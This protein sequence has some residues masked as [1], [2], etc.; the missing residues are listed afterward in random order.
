MIERI[1]PILLTMLAGYLLGSI[2]SAI[3]VS[4]GLKKDD[5][6]KHGSGNAGVA[7]MYRVYGKLPAL[8]TILGDFFKAILSVIL[9]RMIFGV[10]SGGQ[11]LGFDPGYL[12]GLFVLTGHIFPLYFGFRGGKGVMP[13]IGVL[14]VVN[15]PVLAILV[16]VVTPMV[17]LTRKMSLGS[18]IGSILLPPVTYGWARLMAQDV[19][20]AT[21]F[22]VIYAILVLVSHRSNI[23]RLIKGEEQPIAPKKS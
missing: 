13:M 21:L 6:R 22:A 17:L 20:A 9:A 18:V 12:A 1:I 10:F 4:R 23:Q 15:L 5:I 16:V 2:N 8:L 14:F 11:A 19:R 7:N 3:L